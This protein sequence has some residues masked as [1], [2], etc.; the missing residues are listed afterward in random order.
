MQN[1]FENEQSKGLEVDG[2]VFGFAGYK[3]VYVGS[4]VEDLRIL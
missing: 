1:K 4:R 2:L 3:S